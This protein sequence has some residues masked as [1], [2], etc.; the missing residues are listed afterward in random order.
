MNRTEISAT[1]AIAGLF[2]IRMLALFMVLPVLTLYAGKFEGVSATQLGW[3]IGIYGLTQALFQIPLGYI[4]DFIG[5]RKVV[6]IGLL[7]F[8]LGSFIAARAQGIYGLMLGRGLQG[9]GAIGSTLLAYTADLTRE[10]VRTRAMALVGIAIGSSFLLAMVLGP[11][12]SGSYGLQGIFIFNMLLGVIGLIWFGV[13]VPKVKIQP[14]FNSERLS[15][16]AI[17][18]D[19][20]LLRL[21]FSIFVLHAQ[22]AACFL[23]I[24]KLIHQLTHLSQQEVWRVYL[25]ALLGA[26]V[27]MGPFLRLGDKTKTAKPV[28]IGAILLLGL[29]ECFL[30]LYPLDSKS[31]LA[32][33]IVF[34]ASFTLLESQLPAWVSKSS[35]KQSKG[36]VLGI[37]STSQF[38][39]IFLG[40]VVGGMLQNAIGMLGVIFWCILLLLLWLISAL[41]L[42]PPK[43]VGMSKCTTS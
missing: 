19:K 24:P 2:S 1:L 34:F 16:G 22:F 35:P 33:L 11:L 30:G 42:N 8:I 29:S 21:N 20:Q 26:L 40:G 25:P 27:L 14:F 38:L 18:K 3:V 43:L 23:F 7:V 41:D 15:L 12:V 10:E 28:L 32:V 13:A 17:L 6:F 36:F 5:R 31:L 37:Y 39:G 4:S 9:A